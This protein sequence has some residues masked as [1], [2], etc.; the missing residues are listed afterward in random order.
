MDSIFP[1]RILIK[2][3]FVQIVILKL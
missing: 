2:I 3:M 1:F